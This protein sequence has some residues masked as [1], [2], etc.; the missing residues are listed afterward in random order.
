MIK[1]FIH[2]YIRSNGSRVPWAIADTR[3][4]LGHVAADDRVEE[5]K[6]LSESEMTAHE[7]IAEAMAWCSMSSSV[8]DLTRGETSSA[9]DLFH[10]LREL[11][12]TPR[13]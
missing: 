11:T 12:D 4:G 5:V 3:E 7:L 9:W 1:A 8:G 13:G 2:S 10:Y 6:I